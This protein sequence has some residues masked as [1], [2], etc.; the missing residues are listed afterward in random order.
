MSDIYQQLDNKK[1]RKVSPRTNDGF[2]DKD[3]SPE[4]P[5][6]DS[7]L[8]IDESNEK[9]TAEKA[10]AQDVPDYIVETSKSKLLTLEVEVRLQLDRLLYEHKKE[11]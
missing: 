3:V 8:A 7:E 4:S 10:R 2:A 1:N 6:T 11:C 9:L 5:I